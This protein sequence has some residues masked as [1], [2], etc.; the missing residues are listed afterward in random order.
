MHMDLK[1]LIDNLLDLVLTFLSFLS[2]II[3]SNNSLLYLEKK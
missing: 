1:N 2:L 3:L